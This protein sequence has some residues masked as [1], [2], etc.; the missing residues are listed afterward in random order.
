[1]SNKAKKNIATLSPAIRRIRH[2]IGA[3]DLV[4]AGTVMKRWKLCGRPNC[5]CAQEPDARHGPY[6]EWSRR[7]DGRLRHSLLTPAQAAQMTRA[8][9]NQRQILALLVRWSRETARIIM[10]RVQ[11]R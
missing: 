4:C 3:M 6:Y 9:K 11:P 10:A 7:Q 1:M 8:I 2:A 5:R